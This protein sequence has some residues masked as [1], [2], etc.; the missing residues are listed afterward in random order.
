MEKE[1][2]WFTSD[3]HWGHR[4]IVK[5]CPERQ[6]EF[7]L[8]ID[9][10]DMLQK[11]D[12]GLIRR[13]NMTVGKHDTVYI[14]GD[15]SFAPMEDTKK[16]LEKLHGK[17][18][19][20]LGNHD[21][22]CKGLENYFE[23]VS[24]IKEV[25][26]KTHMYPFLEEHMHCVLCHFPLIAW[27]RRMR[28]SIHLHGHLHGSGDDL[29]KNSEELRVDVGFDSILGNCGLVSL[30]KLYYYMKNEVAKGQIFEDHVRE[31]V[32]KTGFIA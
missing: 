1:K 11:H 6:K 30:E 12:E 31:L 22:S 13:W 2:V 28:G 16:I 10:T 26:F 25:W 23:S 29:N 32:E 20:I 5:F 24:Q 27:N 14:L 15:F 4:N 9:D 17:K 19:L 21:K 18:H 7:G 8:D 3:L